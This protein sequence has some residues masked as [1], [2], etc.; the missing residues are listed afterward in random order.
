M[1]VFA[2]GMRKNDEKSRS[3]YPV[4]RQRFEP[5]THQIPSRNFNHTPATSDVESTIYE[6]S[7]LCNFI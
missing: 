3:K 1:P 7:S 5:G 4:F 2:R 6:K